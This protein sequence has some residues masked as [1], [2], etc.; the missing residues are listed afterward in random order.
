[1]AR[2]DLKELGFQDGS[3][4]LPKV[5][6]AVSAEIDSENERRKRAGFTAGIR[7]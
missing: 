2:Q 1:M 6:T 4:K 3:S 7:K 5:D